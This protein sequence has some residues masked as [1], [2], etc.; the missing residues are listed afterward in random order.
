MLK[1]YITYVRFWK[2]ERITHFRTLSSQILGDI[3]IFQVNRNLGPIDTG[4]HMDVKYFV[5]DDWQMHNKRALGWYF[6]P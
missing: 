3:N 1:K 5:S 4:A 2:I 6:D